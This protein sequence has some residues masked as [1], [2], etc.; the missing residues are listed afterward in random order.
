VNTQEKL[1]RREWIGMGIVL[2]AILTIFV[3]CKISEKRIYGLLQ[4][5]VS[6]AKSPSK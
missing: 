2:G 4:K 6:E 1:L 5:A 3:V